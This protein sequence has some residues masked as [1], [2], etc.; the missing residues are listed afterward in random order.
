M[1]LAEAAKHT[2]RDGQS[3]HLQVRLFD[4]IDFFAEACDSERIFIQSCED[5]QR[6][7]K[8]GASY[9]ACKR[10]LSPAIRVTQPAR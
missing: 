5:S 8:V 7:A 2:N 10:D 1:N 3:I 6:I 4:P 9:A